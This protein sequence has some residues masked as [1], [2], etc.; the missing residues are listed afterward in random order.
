LGVRAA[1]LKGRYEI[2]EFLSQRDGICRF[3]GLDHGAG[4]AE[5]VAVVIVRGE[6]L[7]AAEPVPEPEDPSSRN[8]PPTDDQLLPL[9]EQATP[10]ALPTT[11]NLGAAPAW[12]G[13]AWEHHILTRA[14]HP[15]LPA[16]LDDF[17]EE[18]YEYL[19]EELPTGAPLW[20]AWAEAT[21]EQRFGWLHQLA[22]ALHELHH[23]GTVHE[24][25]CPGIFVITS[26]GNLR[27][28]GVGDLLPLPLRSDVQVRA[29]LYTAPELVLDK[30][31]ADAR[32]DLYGF[33]ALLY[34]LH[35]GRELADMDFEMQGV[36]KPFI[37]RFPDIHPALGRLI[38]RTFCRDVG[39][40]F[41]SDE[42]A[43]ED[44][45]G[46]ID[47]M[48]TLAVCGAVM[49]NVR[50]EVAA[51][52]TTG[53]VRTGNEDAFALLH[54]VESRQDHLG[55]AVL[56]LLADGMGGYEAGEV[57]AGLAVQ[58]MRRHLL[59]QR[60]FAL[61]A[62]STAAA[63]APLDLE[64]CEQYLCAA[65]REANQTIFHAAADG[66]GRRGMGC[67]AEAVYVNGRHVVVGHVGDSRTYHL[68]RSEL[69]QALGGHADVSPAIYQ[70]AMKVGD[71][72]VVCSDGLSNHVTRDELQHMLQTEAT[73]AEM[74]A[75]RL[76][77]L[78]NIKGTTD[79]ATVVVIRAL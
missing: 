26:A 47:L 11:D 14:Q 61:L 72:V 16:V 46:F 59:A 40:R 71:W 32:A 62:G 75:R 51:W 70:G 37:P 43:L 54:A 6:P 45:T 28:A 12:P 63:Q 2:G 5:P 20:D 44:L 8:A 30:E 58:T 23:A 35:V 77:N 31:R 76:V 50:L 39:G 1:R 67:T 60:M 13:P 3:R 18:P 79:N 4:T 49:A 19:V 7:P 42:A 65:L 48:Q 55:E 64:T 29:T 34:A 73:S 74:A 9:C 25:L 68:R 10:L 33:G 78:A 38:S 15:A 53:M 22:E 17:F 66:V 69:Q 41:P 24:S 21:A 56:V 57:A 36:P 27:F 52:T